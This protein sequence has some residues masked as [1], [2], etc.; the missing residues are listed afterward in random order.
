M[1]SEKI[2]FEDVLVNNALVLK[3]GDGEKLE[4]NGNSVVLKISSENT[5][6]Q[7]G[8]Y[9]V[10]LKPSSMGA[11][12]HYHRFMD[13]TFIVLKGSPTVTMGEKEMVLSEGS[14]V[15]VPKFTVHGFRNDSH[16]NCKML[17][18]F[19]PAMRREGFFRGLSYLLN[20][21]KLDSTKFRKLYNKYD[22]YLVE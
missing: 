18:V 6:N 22:S 5:D 2:F 3:E 12:P 7:L 4:V 19:N 20:K 15:F 13:E 1:K 10:N 16:S 11:K 21:D 17:I 14:V 9:E 8:V